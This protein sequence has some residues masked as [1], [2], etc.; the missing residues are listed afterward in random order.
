MAHTAQLVLCFLAS[1]SLAFGS[2]VRLQS[3]EEEHETHEALQTGAAS[4]ESLSDEGVGK[5]CYKEYCERNFHEFCEY[6]SATGK[7]FLKNDADAKKH[8]AGCSGMMSSYCGK[9]CNSAY[10]K[11]KTTKDEICKYDSTTQKFSLEKTKLSQLECGSCW[12]LC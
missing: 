6:D 8:C 2:R 7:T 11:K 1:T 5:K 4:N 3:L 12:S 9:R 10:C